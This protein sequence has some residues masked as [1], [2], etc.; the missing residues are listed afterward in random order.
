MIASGELIQASHANERLYLL[1]SH[2]H[3]PD[4]AVE[5][6]SR[7]AHGLE[8]RTTL[9]ENSYWRR[10]RLVSEFS[11]VFRIKILRDPTPMMSMSFQASGQARRPG[12]PGLALV[13]RRSLARRAQ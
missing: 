6:F 2:H 12:E 7:R 9:G 13:Q 4:E 1:P 8:R 5:R 3:Q 10:G 11:V